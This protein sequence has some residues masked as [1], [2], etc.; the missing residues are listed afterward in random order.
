MSSFPLPQF[1]E[2]WRR[3]E[4]AYMD[5]FIRSLKRLAEREKLYG[6]ENRINKTLSK[7]TNDICFE[8]WNTEKKDINRPRYEQPIPPTDENELTEDND[9]KRPDFSC[10]F[11]NDFAQKPEEREIGLH[12]ECKL[13][14]D[15]DS[16][17]NLNRNYVNNGIKRFLHNTHE[18]GKRAPAGLM[19]GYMI[20]MLPPTIQDD[21]NGHIKKEL[22]GNPEINFVFSGITS[23]TE[24][25]L[26]RS[27]VAPNDF[28]LNHIWVDLRNNY[29]FERKKPK[30]LK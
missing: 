13:L 2:L 20:N 1:H 23:K 17:W 25:K 8:L 9:S 10:I 24:Q 16:S 12:C 6:G 7:I 26:F 27:D 5:V 14:G 21:V 11:K 28:V 4:N 18:Y 15:I 22:H 3:H 29:K 30:V 19:I